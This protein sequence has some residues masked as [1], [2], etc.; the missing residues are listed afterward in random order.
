M[1]GRAPSL[2]PE[3]QQAWLEE[4]K[5]GRFRTQVEMG[6]WLRK[7][8]G[9]SLSRQGIDYWVK[10]FKARLKVPRPS[11]I[12]KQK[13]EAEN[14]KRDFIHKLEALP[15][16]S[17]Q[18]VKVWIQ[19]EGRYGLKS[20]TRRVWGLPGERVV[21]GSQQK[22]EWGYVYGAL[23]CTSGAAEFAYLPTVNQELMYKFLHQIALSDP[24]AEHV[25]V[26]DQ[27]GFHFNPGDSRLPDRVH[28]ICLPA[29]SPELNP[30][31]KVWDYLKDAICNRV[32]PSL[33]ELEAAISERLS[34]IWEDSARCL[35]FVGQGWLRLS[36]N[37]T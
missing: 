11:H 25:V 30:V 4:L 17:G 5:R 2:N 24:A 6:S 19:D 36:A 23:E 12:K 34:P 15:I 32:Y 31:E 9:V 1:C 29:Y 28:V 20:F 14:F 3:Q 26:Y 21:V 10:K 7:E 27:A 22:Y 8:H 16:S 13:E 33:E 18:S 37:N 35:G